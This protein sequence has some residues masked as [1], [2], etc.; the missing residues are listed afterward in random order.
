MHQPSSVDLY[1]YIFPLMS[2]GK[3]NFPAEGL[4]TRMVYEWMR[5]SMYMSLKGCGN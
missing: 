5:D 4:L 3:R 1:A 2:V